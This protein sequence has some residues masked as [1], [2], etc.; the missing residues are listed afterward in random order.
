MQTPA[1]PELSLVAGAGQR[2]ES[3]RQLLISPRPAR[4]RHRSGGGAHGKR[5]MHE[6][7]NGHQ[8]LETTHSEPRFRALL[9]DEKGDARFDVWGQNLQP[10]GFVF[11]GLIADEGVTVELVRA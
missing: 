7:L 2:L 4:W 3:A 11:R 8:R 6:A 10:L 1:T 5:F 9:A